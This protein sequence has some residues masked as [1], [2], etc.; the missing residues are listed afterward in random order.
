M[1]KKMEPIRFW[2]AEN[3]RSAS[4]EFTNAQHNNSPT[5]SHA[6]SHEKNVQMFISMPV[7]FSELLFIQCDF[8]FTH[9]C[10]QRLHVFNIFRKWKRK[11]QMAYHNNHQLKNSNRVFQCLQVWTY[12]YI[13]HFSSYFQLNFRL[14]FIL[15]LFS[16]AILFSMKKTMDKKKQPSFTLNDFY[17]KKTTSLVEV[18]VSNL[19]IQFHVLFFFKRHFKFDC[20]CVVL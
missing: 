11:L 1:W 5:T 20:I 6:T 8:I 16:E 10:T 3:T 15:L 2:Y 19:T 12:V 18:L 13:K 14:F 7:T 4:I 17:L 9:R